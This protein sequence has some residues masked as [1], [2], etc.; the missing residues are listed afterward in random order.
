MVLSGLTVEQTWTLIF[1]I[2]AA[3]STILGIIGITTYFNTR[4]K[5][6]AEKK[7]N[8]E[9]EEEKKKKEAE[10]KAEEEKHQKQLNEI[11]EVIKEEVAPI[12]EETTHIKD[13]LD[14]VAEG[15][16]DILRER[17]LSC[18]YKCMKKGYRTQYDYENVDH[19]F[20]E[21]KSLNG[22]SFV[23]E[24]V[25]AIKALPSEEQWKAK[26]KLAAKKPRAKKTIL[27][28]NK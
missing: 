8:Q 20:R 12:K 28:E 15:T 2:I 19:M 10:A 18:Y 27:V 1:G 4:M 13:K 7:N 16:T 3:F 6:K 11:R 9:D 5:H 17:L 22:N 24:C 23:E 14:I 21:Y 25:T 26:K